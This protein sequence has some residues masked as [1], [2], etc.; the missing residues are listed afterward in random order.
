M[1]EPS[2]RRSFF[3]QIVRFLQAGL[4]LFLTI[5]IVRYIPY[6]ILES[7]ASEDMWSSAGNVSDIP[8]GDPQKRTFLVAEHDGWSERLVERSVWVV[9]YDEDR[10]AVYSALCP[11]QGCSINWKPESRAFKCPC[12]E[13]AFDLEGGLRSGPS[14]R[15]L[16]KV[17]YK[18]D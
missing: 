12:H 9:R 11:H 17:E 14:P 18:T 5:P 15:G 3:R 13:S 16:D 8:I 2:D 10:A 4:A 6:P 7:H 1:N